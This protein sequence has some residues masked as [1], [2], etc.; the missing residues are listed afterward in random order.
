MRGKF[1][2]KIPNCKVFFLSHTSKLNNRSSEILFQK[3]Q[4]ILNPPNKSDFFPVIILLTNH[5]ALYN[6]NI[7]H[8]LSQSLPSLQLE[9]CDLKCI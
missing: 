6:L 4:Q 3:E 5:E 8:L 2:L 7:V 9:V 1:H